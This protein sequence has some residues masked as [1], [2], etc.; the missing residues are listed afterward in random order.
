M[1]VTLPTAKSKPTTD[2]AKQ[3]ILIYG[4]PKLGKC[5][6]GDTV[7]YDPT[8]GQPTALKD[9][10]TNQEG[11]VLTMGM[12]GVI[13]PAQ[14]SNYIDNG[15]AALFRVTTQSGRTIDATA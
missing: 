1:T 13:K 14:P 12:A 3:S 6:A 7:L 10:V 4:A 15:E 11:E 9:L 2:L 8:T 5:L